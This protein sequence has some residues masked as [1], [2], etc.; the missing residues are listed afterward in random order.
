MKQTL[1]TAKQ[2]I[3]VVNTGI[4][5][6]PKGID[7]KVVE[8]LKKS[9]KEL[10]N[11]YDLLTGCKSVTKRKLTFRYRFILIS[12]TLLINSRNSKRK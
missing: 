1:D 11:L 12:R 9:P 7:Q 3:S 5:E 8:N 6:L 2:I 4:G 10:K